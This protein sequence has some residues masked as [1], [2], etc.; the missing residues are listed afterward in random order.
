MNSWKWDSH[1]EH[2]VSENKKLLIVNL[3]TSWFLYHTWRSNQWRGG[4]SSW[5]WRTSCERDTPIINCQLPGSLQQSSVLSKDPPPQ[6]FVPHTREPR[7]WTSESQSPSP[8]P[9]RFEV[10]QQSSPPLHPT[11]VRCSKITNKARMRTVFLAPPHYLQPGEYLTSLIGAVS[12]ISF[13]LAPSP[14]W[15]NV[16]PTGVYLCRAPWRPLRPP[17]VSTAVEVDT[18]IIFKGEH[19]QRGFGHRWSNFDAVCHAGIVWKWHTV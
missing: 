15:I 1:E 13:H 17:W 3:R 8:S 12:S 10:V 11:K 4:S 2:G 5:N 16:I 9:Q 14:M 18:S 19:T 6:L 7:H